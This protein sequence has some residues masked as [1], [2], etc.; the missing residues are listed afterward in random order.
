MTDTK[1]LN[2]YIA[3]IFLHYI[4]QQELPTENQVLKITSLC[5]RLVGTSL[6]TDEISEQDKIGI[7]HAIKLIEEYLEEEGV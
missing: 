3:I 5:D 1:K 7:Q 4:G 2:A 6:C